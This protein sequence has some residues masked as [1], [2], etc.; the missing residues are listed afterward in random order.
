VYGYALPLVIIQI[1][2]IRED[3][4]MGIDE[5]IEKTRVELYEF[6][7]SYGTVHVK[8]ILK[9]QELDILL[10]QRGKVCA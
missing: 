5:L 9:S 6:I 2:N 4:K 10:N 1:E 3:I 8:T 7:E